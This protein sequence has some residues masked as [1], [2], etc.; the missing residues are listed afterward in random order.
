M[1]RTKILALIFI[2]SVIIFVFV[3]LITGDRE[4]EVIDGLHIDAPKPTYSDPQDMPMRPG[5]PGGMFFE[6]DIDDLID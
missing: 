6:D 2:L 1:D 5:G 4:E 3:L